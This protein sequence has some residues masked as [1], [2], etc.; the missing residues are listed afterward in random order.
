MP[1]VG[2]RGHG[3]LYVAV[4]ASIPQKLN[5]EQQALIENLDQTM[6]DRAQSPTQNPGDEDEERPFF[7]RVKDIFG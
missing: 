1:N 3:D 2:G 4:Q 7:D 6:P 5:Q